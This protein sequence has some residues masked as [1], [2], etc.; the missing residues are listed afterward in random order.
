VACFEVRV[1]DM[2]TK[3]YTLTVRRGSVTIAEIEDA[4]ADVLVAGSRDDWIDA[5]GPDA[6]R[7]GLRI[8][9]DQRLASLLLDTVAA[10]AERDVRVA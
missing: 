7:R 8:D 5:L 6:D 10:G 1:D 4:S 9:G 3:H 2:T